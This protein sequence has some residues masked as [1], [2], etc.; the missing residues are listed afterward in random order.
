LTLLSVRVQPRSSQRKVVPDGSGGYKVWVTAA[1]V[2]GA[3]NEAVI[4]LL[5][6]VLGS[7][8]RLL[9]GS[10]SRTKVFSVELSPEEVRKIL[11]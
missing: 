1:P 9:K 11:G 5:S 3:A 10:T 7:S 6:D 8:V 4:D 2:D